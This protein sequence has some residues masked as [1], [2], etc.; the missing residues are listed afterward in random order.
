MELFFI[1][2]FIK[3]PKTIRF[4]LDSDLYF[5][6][7][8]LAINEIKSVLKKDAYH[9]RFH[10]LLSSFTESFVPIAHLLSVV[11]RDCLLPV[12]GF[13]N[14]YSTHTVWKFHSVSCKF[15]PNGPLP[16]FRV[17][18]SLLSSLF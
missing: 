7:S 5:L 2:N 9:E 6:P 14:L 11:G 3:Y 16:Y 13:S 12:V 1:L 17:Q 10:Y 15:L 4:L 18:V 8:Y